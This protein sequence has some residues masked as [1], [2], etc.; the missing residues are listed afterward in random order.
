[1]TLDP[2]LSAP[3]EIRLHLAFAAL[4][5]VFGPV[6]L[7]RGRRDLVHRVTG[8]V[9]A[10]GMVGLAVTGLF[11]ESD[12][13][14]IGHFGPI[15]LFSVYALFS[16][17]KAIHHARQGNHVAHAGWMRGLWFAG[18]GITGLLTLLP[19]RVLN[20]ALFGEPDMAGVAVM[21]VGVLA[22]AWLWHRQRR[23]EPLLRRA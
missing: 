23:G 7:F 14:V 16:L 1:M 20:R 18:L 13:P 10:V 19:G 9:G 6:A 21:A 3:F 12:F 15:H 8:Y 11:I 2:I 5:L 22:L 17:T 4:A